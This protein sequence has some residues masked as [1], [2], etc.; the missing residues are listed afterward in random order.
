MTFQLMIQ[1]LFLVIEEKKNKSQIFEIQIHNS[2]FFHRIL[3]SH[4][5]ILFSTME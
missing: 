5:T 3:S 1:T 2:D 4:L